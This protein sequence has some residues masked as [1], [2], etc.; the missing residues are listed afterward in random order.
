VSIQPDETLSKRFPAEMPYRIQII[1]KDGRT[2]SIEKQDYEGFYTRPLSWEKA[3]A[4]FERLAASFTSP[5]QR[6]AI[7]TTVAHLETKEVSQLTELLGAV[8]A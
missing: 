3:V 2:L 7:A 8:R 4:K 5:K 6:S 1:L